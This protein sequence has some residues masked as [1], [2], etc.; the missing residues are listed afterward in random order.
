[1]GKVEPL[2]DGVND[3]GGEFIKQLHPP[4][5]LVVAKEKTS[6]ILEVP[7]KRLTQVLTS[8]CGFEVSKVQNNVRTKG[9]CYKDCEKTVEMF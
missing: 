2:Q 3:V 7:R 5:Q 1:M 8:I 4:Q 6:V 9:I